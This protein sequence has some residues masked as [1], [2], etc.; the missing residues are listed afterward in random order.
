MDEET[1]RS[2]ITN[3]AKHVVHS[4]THAGSESYMQQKMHDIIAISEPIGHP[5]VFITM[6]SNA[7][8]PEFQNALLLVQKADDRPDLCG[9]VFRMKL[10]LLLKHLR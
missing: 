9:R 5:D 7:Y 1:G 8:R 3:I 6:T 10:N 4:S 2:Q